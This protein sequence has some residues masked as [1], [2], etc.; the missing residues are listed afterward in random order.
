[1][2]ELASDSSTSICNILVTYLFLA[3]DEWH[4]PNGDDCWYDCGSQP[5]KC[6]YCGTFGYCCSGSKDDLNAGC[7]TE[8]Q[9][10]IL[11]SEYDDYQHVCV[12]KFE[13]KNV[14]PF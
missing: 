1:M 3:N 10:A 4:V 5:G 6:D 11:N 13:G 9:N 12:V 8:M 2:L 14:P 7:T